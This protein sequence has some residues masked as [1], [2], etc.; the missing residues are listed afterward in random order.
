M[1]KF[2][3]SLL[4][5]GDVT[6]SPEYLWPNGDA[7]VTGTIDGVAVAG[8]GQA[9]IQEYTS[10][11]DAC[12]PSY[13][14][15]VVS[16]LEEGASED[17]VGAQ[18]VRIAIPWSGELPAE[19]GLAPTIIDLYGA[20]VASWLDTDGV[21]WGGSEGTAI[22]NV[23]DEAGSATIDITGMRVCELLSMQATSGYSTAESCRTGGT[24]QVSIVWN[25]GVV[26]R[27]VDDGA[28][29]HSNGWC[30]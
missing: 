3:F 5:C 20:P 18:D 12:T 15:G 7:V 1:W 27:L 23:D 10:A 19:V 24:A 26:G 21:A 8:P 30:H 11:T 22:L 13:D 25:L 28:E 17:L 6:V 29:L 2:I 4:A 16:V 9:A 14:F